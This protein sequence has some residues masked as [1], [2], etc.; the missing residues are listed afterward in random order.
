MMTELSNSLLDMCR[1]VELTRGSVGKHSVEVNETPELSMA[2]SFG[3]RREC[4]DQGLLGYFR[5]LEMGMEQK[6]PQ[7]ERR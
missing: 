6:K 4:L 7:Q 3:W 1:M 2:A 5:D